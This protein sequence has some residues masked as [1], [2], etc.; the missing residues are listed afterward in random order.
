MEM[1]PDVRGE[2]RAVSP[3]VI[4]KGE[5]DYLLSFTLIIATQ[6]EEPVLRELA[7]VCWASRTPLLI[8]RSYGLLGYLR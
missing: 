8:A 1:N 4:I 2:Y 3:E 7:Q 5:P 6:L